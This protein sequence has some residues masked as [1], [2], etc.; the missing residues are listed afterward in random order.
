MCIFL[1][2][3]RV[4][5][6]NEIMDLSKNEVQDFIDELEN[7]AENIENEI[8]NFCEKV[9]DT[10]TRTEIDAIRV[11]W[12]TPE[13]ATKEYQR[14]ARSDYEA[15]YISARSL[16]EEYLPEKLKIF[17]NKHKK[18]KKRINLEVSAKMSSEELYNQIINS[19]DEQRNLVKSI[20][21]KI[22]AE[23]F[24]ARRQI[25]SR[26]VRD[27]IQQARELFDDDFVRASGVVAAVAL[28]RHL[29]TICENS[30]KV[31][32]YKAN[33]GITRLAQTLYE[34]EEIN[35]TVW[36]DIKALASIRETCAH[37]EEPQK[38]A[39]RR[40]INESEELIREI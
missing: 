9:R 40:L 18:F 21:A 24:K 5:N 34:S 31:T 10:T 35:K 14:D 8:E 36:N 29:L 26:M 4:S 6:Q 13:G 12:Q 39:V 27:E 2:I 33:H 37:P 28:E 16:I 3:S 23:K 15:W 38:E 32:E 19:F 7:D 25:S 1:L 17:E 11:E 20:P 30:E 22:R